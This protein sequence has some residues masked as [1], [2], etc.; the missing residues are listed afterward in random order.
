MMANMRAEKS[1]IFNWMVEGLRRLMKN[2]TFTSSLQLSE[3]TAEYRGLNDNVIQFLNTYCTRVA[4][5]N[6]ENRISTSHLYEVYQMFTEKDNLRCVSKKV[7][8]QRILDA[9][10]ERKNGL[11][12]KTNTTYFSGLALNY[13]SD[14]VNQY[15]LEIRIILSR[16]N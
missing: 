5:D 15:L 6:A 1:G 12:D 7:F 11:V 3:Y 16:N 8:T 9:G 2:D 13:Q 4:V 10:F 14:D